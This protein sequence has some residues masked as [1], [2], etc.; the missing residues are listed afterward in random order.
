[1]PQL[2]TTIGLM[3]GTSADG[4][5]AACIRTDGVH[6][7]EVLAALTL[8]YADR[9]RERLIEAASS[10][11][12]LD[13]VLELE[14]E[15][16]RLHALAVTQ[17]SGHVGMALDEIDL[18]GFHGHTL[19]HDPQSA[20]SC[21]IGDGVL[22]AELTGRPVVFDFRRAD[23][24]AGGE[25]APLA[26][27][28]HAAILGD[29]PRPQMVLNL[30]GVA[31]LTWVGEGDTIVAGDTGPGCGLLDLWAR[32]HLG[33]PYDH[34]GRLALAGQVDE[35]SVARA[36]KSVGYFA[37]DLPKSADRYEFAAIDVSHLSPADGAATLSA[38]T[39]DAVV[40]AVK[41]LPATPVDC[42][43]TGGGANHPVIIERLRQHLPHV[44]KV[45]EL[46][47]DPESLEAA[48]FGWLAV[49]QR[50]GLPTSLPSTTGVAHPVCGGVFV[51]PRGT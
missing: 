46:G 40:D 17:V 20:R 48:C 7:I 5:D 14:Q 43:V 31:N 37:R 4:I 41:R 9:F 33:Q 12:T 1:M 15:L 47:H 26:P 39:A 10:T 32:Q 51:E 2:H 8:P 36:I 50:R 25:G 45:S 11:V 13:E 27:L 28:Y 19:R 30:G 42:W 21:Q 22:L 6:Q 18:I 35:D 49:R 3:S 24:A 29:R 44:E 23:L 16:T 38:I 34:E